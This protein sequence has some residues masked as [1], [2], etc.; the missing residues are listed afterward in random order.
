MTT[1]PDALPLD[2]L[3]ATVNDVLDGADAAVRSAYD[4]ALASLA[5]L[6]E[7]VGSAAAAALDLDRQHEGHLVALPDPR[8]EFPPRLRAASDDG[9]LTIAVAQNEA[10]AA[11]LAAVLPTPEHGPAEPWNRGSVSRRARQFASRYGIT[12]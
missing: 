2:E 6:T 7:A 3:A 5:G 8:A 12:Q 4:A 1:T 9:T 10:L 11:V